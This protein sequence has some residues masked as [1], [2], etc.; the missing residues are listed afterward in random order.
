MA[1]KAKAKS[2]ALPSSC[3]HRGRV[4]WPSRRHCAL[5]TDGP[6]PAASSAGK[7]NQLG[8]NSPFLPRV[9]FHGLCLCLKP[10][11]WGLRSAEGLA[12]VAMAFS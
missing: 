12:G 11:S 6:I 9:Y 5:G 8:T 10:A 7:T 1:A 4:T 3:G 2:K